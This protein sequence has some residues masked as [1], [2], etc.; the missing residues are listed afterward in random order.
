MV[1]ARLL[2]N[3]ASLA[4]EKDRLQSAGKFTFRPGV[5]LFHIFGRLPIYHDV[6]VGLFAVLGDHVS[7]HNIDD[8][9]QGRLPAARR[10][11]L[12]TSRE[13]LHDVIR[14][15][16]GKLKRYFANLI[17]DGIVRGI[18]PTEAE[19]SLSGKSRIEPSCNGR[20]QLR[21]AMDISE[22][23]ALGR[24]GGVESDASDED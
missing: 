1:V 19:A 22:R 7:R 8:A 18:V 15:R 21:Y 14:K 2:V 5:A 24:W 23:A 6:L 3:N 4:G 11:R 10:F 13:L 12:I 20:R 16:L 17:D 9:L